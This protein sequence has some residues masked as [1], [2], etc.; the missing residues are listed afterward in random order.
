MINDELFNYVIIDKTVVLA[1][2][3]INHNDGRDV[4]MILLYKIIYKQ[5]KISNPLNIY[6]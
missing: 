3:V 1:Q 4:L 5:M 2:F 6:L